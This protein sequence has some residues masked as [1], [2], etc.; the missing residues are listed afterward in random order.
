MIVPQASK[1]QSYL[2]NN[3][4]AFNNTTYHKTINNT[5]YDFH[6]HNNYC[7]RTSAANSHK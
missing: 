4:M 6:K 1:I 3:N 2:L 7:L 5:R